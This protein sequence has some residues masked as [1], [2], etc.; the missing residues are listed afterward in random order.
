[1]DFLIGIKIELCISTEIVVI[2]SYSLNQDIY[3]KILRC[4]QLHMEWERVIS[5]DMR[6][7]KLMK[8]LVLM[9]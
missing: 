4:C 2:V 1:M 6:M 3:Y 9:E 5:V 7:T 8:C